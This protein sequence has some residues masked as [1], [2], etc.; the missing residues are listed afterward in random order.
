[1]APRFGVHSGQ[2]NLAMDDLRRLWRW[3]DDA[4]MDLITVW[5]HF[6]EAPPKDG[7]SPHF[8]S[9]AC[10]T[11]IAAETENVRIGCYVFCV[12]YRN[13]ATLAKTLMT[14][15]QVS[16]GRLEAGLGAGWHA[17][18]FRA[19]GYGFPPLRDRFEMLE[20]GT[21]II[22]G[23]LD[24]SQ[25]HTS[26]EGKYYQAINAT[27][28][29]G[30]VQEHVPIWI[31]GKGE[32]KTLRLAAKYADGWNVPYIGLEEFERLSGVLDEHCAE[33]G[34]DPTTIRRSI[35][36]QF[37]LGST[38]AAADAAREKLEAEWGERAGEIA[39]G[40][41]LGTPDD[42][43]ERVSQFVEAGAE[44]VSVALRAPW[45]EAALTA[46]VEEVVPALRKRFADR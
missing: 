22:R 39:E 7:L 27:N 5:D 17:M 13:P 34:R 1:M 21:Q 30:P 32:R 11:T 23:M 29:P 26:F 42:A 35:N 37:N 18:E 36:L 40:A 3:L 41:L 14:I 10:M 15:D 8:E 2:Q 6:Y 16:H 45:D 9:T 33:V 38:A 46:Y 19:Y 20:E 12:P 25:Q 4:G 44:G 24:R 28:L 31:G 43:F